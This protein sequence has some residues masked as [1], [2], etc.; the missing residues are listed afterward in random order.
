MS[1]Q[2]EFSTKVRV[3][4]R[5]GVVVTAKEIQ[6]DVYCNNNNNDDDD[7][8]DDGRNQCFSLLSIVNCSSLHRTQHY[9]INIVHTLPHINAIE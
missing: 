5:D 1:R 3:A 7:D 9:S 4:G 8:E 2:N 6:N